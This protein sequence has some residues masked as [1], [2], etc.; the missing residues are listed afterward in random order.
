MNAVQA[1][2]PEGRIE[3][4]CAPYGESVASFSV[5]DTGSGIAPQNL[6]HLF[7]PF[8]TT[9]GERGT[10]LGLSITAGIVE[11][12]GGSIHVVSESGAGS[13][14]TVVLPRAGD[15]SRRSLR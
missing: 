2:P 9:K 6:P 12:H 10:G 5:A 7:E 8:F 15:V 14:F 13:T 11:D 3:V 1:T 4:S